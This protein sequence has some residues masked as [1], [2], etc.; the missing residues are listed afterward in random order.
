MLSNLHYMQTHIEL[1]L[2]S[3]LLWIL[4][5]QDIKVLLLLLIIIASCIYTMKYTVEYYQKLKPWVLPTSFQSAFVQLS[6]AVLC[7]VTGEEV[8]G[9]SSQQHVYSTPS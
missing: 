9:P 7:D 3:S 2:F 5:G 1:T 6:W 4:G 8:C